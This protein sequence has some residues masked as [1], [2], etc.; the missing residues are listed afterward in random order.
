M[1]SKELHDKRRRA[2]MESYEQIRLRCWHCR[3]PMDEVVGGAA[4]VDAVGRMWC[5]CK[6]G[7][8]AK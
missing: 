8:E 2:A 7:K 6:K 4:N 5:G 1:T 3:R